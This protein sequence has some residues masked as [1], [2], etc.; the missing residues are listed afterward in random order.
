M[1]DFVVLDL[2]FSI[3]RQEVGLGNVSEMTY[4]VSSGT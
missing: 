3:P 1:C 4:F 2:F